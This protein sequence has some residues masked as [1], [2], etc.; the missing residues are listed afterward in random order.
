MLA[1][2]PVLADDA[3]SLLAFPALSIFWT[4]RRIPKRIGGDGMESAQCCPHCKDGGTVELIHV[5]INAARCSTRRQKR[6]R[7]LCPCFGAPAAGWDWRLSVSK[8]LGRLRRIGETVAVQNNLDHRCERRGELPLISHPHDSQ[9]F[10]DDAGSL[11]WS[12][13]SSASRVSLSGATGTF[14]HSGDAAFRSYAGSSRFPSGLR[15]CTLASLL[16]GRK[17]MPGSWP[18]GPLLSG[19]VVV[20]IL[21]LSHA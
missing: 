15:A 20:F 18:H 13:R 6:C 3:H 7:N 5:A 19:K 16:T 9:V 17:T 8:C 21:C 1:L 12:A 2:S 11:C 4:P 14:A 10:G